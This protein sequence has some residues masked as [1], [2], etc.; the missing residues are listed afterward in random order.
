[1]RNNWKLV[2]FL[3]LLATVP[4]NAQTSD[5]KRIE[6][7]PFF[8][9]LFGGTVWHS[10][11]PPPLWTPGFLIADHTTYGMRLGFNL[12]RS[13]EPEIQWS[14]TDTELSIRELDPLTI[15]FFIASVNYNFD[16]G[17]FRPY[18]GVG[19]GAGLFDGINYRKHTLFTT[20]FALGT[21]FFFTPNFG[22]RL[23]ARGYASKPDH[24]IKRTCGQCDNRWILNGDLTGGITVAF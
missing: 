2:L 18:V 10:D 23:E 14:H 16:A 24:I 15:D 1:M 19:L 20:S 5:T 3:A 21:K 11:F 4:A 6:V 9:Y 7:T 13:L 17:C 22:L 12:T 8:G